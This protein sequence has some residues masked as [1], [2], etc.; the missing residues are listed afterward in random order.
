MTILE[1]RE[2]LVTRGGV[3]RLHLSDVCLFVY[4]CAFFAHRTNAGFDGYLLRGS[5]VL[6]VVCFFFF[7]ILSDIKKRKKRPLFSGMAVWLICFWAFAIAS[8]FWSESVKNTLQGNYITNAI[9]AII[10]VTFITYR[11]RDKDDL[12]MM[13]KLLVAAGLYAAVVLYMRTPS[14]TWGSERVGEALGLNQNT[15]GM[16]N[17]YL[18]LFCLFLLHYKKSPLAI[19]GVIA[20]VTI[21]LF[22]GSRKAFLIIVL[23][24]L[25][26]EIFSHRGFKGLAAALIALA[27]VYS[28]YQLVMTVPAFYDVLGYRIERLLNNG[29]DGSAAER[30]WYREY[31]FSMWANR[32]LFGYGFNGFLTQMQAINYWHQA[33]CH[34]NQL[35]LLADLGIAGFSLYYGFYVAML[36]SFGKSFR[37]HRKESVFGISFILIAFIAEYGNVA[38][39]GVDTYIF[40]ALVYSTYR[41]AT[42]EGAIERENASNG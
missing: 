14:S 19:A 29:V 36:R 2:K 3:W 32:P 8:V 13:V 28:L 38:F 18:A 35:E 5:F 42:H 1:G 15:V 25:L 10:L 30:Q 11:I 20:F 31:A 6:Y 16:N 39:V 40:L 27:A 12:L 17:A 4:L 7:D 34:C 23:G 21:A 41:V 33:Y 22:S 26:I 37:N 24:I 9:Q